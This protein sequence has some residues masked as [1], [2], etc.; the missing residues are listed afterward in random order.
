MLHMQQIL[1]FHLLC[2][3]EQMMTEFHGS[4]KSPRLPRHFDDNQ[5][6]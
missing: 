1:L 6:G 3:L 4:G 2:L 5:N